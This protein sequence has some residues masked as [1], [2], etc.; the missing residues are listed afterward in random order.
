MLKEDIIKLFEQ[1]NIPFYKDP[2]FWISTIISLLLGG[3]SIIYS[4]KSFKE[5]KAAKEEASKAGNTVKRQSIII[6]IMEITKLCQLTFNDDYS[7]VS[8]K[9]NDIF[10]VY[11][12]MNSKQQIITLYQN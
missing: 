11:I 2:G 4:F 3:I 5:A 7:S 9:F 6:D 10:L 12:K 1:F 8:T